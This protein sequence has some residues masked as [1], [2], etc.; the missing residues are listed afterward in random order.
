[1]RSD[2]AKANAN[3]KYTALNAAPSDAMEIARMDDA[4]LQA[5]SQLATR[6]GS[7]VGTSTTDFPE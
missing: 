6:P 3:A 4:A 1:M 2:G 5:R 7:G